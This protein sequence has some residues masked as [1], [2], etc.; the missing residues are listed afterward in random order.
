[1]TLDSSALLA[2]LLSES[3]SLDLVDQILDADVVRVG[4]PTLAET[5]I[6]L[7]SRRGKPSAREVERLIE[8]LGVTV[9]PFGAAEWTVAV[10]AYDRFGRGKHAARLNFG[11]C[12]AY[13]TARTAGDSLLFVGND[14]SKTDVPRA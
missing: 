14:F 6:V 10:D 7:G 13:A 2:I 12:L 3:G 8:E 4:T 5:S 1:M 9:V 11:D